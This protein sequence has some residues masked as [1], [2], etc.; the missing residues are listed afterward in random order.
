MF[1]FFKQ[2]DMHISPA[3]ACLGRPH[4]IYRMESPGFN[5]GFV[6]TEN[7]SVRNGMISMLDPQGSKRHAL[8][9]MKTRRFPNS[10]GKIGDSPL[11]QSP[12]PHCT[13]WFDIH[14]RGLLLYIPQ[15]SN[16]LE[17]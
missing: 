17:T 10:K 9:E 5:G 12:K 16:E 1:F 14:L 13:D 7:P 11:W 4:R 6:R 15:T 3:L 8:C 2:Q